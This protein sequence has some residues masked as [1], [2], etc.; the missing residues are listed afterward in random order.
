[1]SQLLACWTPLADGSGASDIGSTNDGGLTAISLRQAERV[2]SAMKSVLQFAQTDRDTL[3]QQALLAAGDGCG[4]VLLCAAEGQ[5]SALIKDLEGVSAWV[6]VTQL[7]A[8][9]WLYKVALCSPTEC[10][11]MLHR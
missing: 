10:H 9:H 11:A 7:P 4:L 5:I 8:L 6:H 1:M 3:G 2:G